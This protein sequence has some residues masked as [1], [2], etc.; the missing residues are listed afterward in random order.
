VI[1]SVALVWGG[2]QRAPTGRKAVD[3][4]LD[5]R[6]TRPPLYLDF[7]TLVESLGSQEGEARKVRYGRDEKAMGNWTI[8]D[9]G[10]L[11]RD[12]RLELRGSLPKILTGRNDALLDARGTHDG[13]RELV[14]LGDSLIRDARE[15]ANELRQRDGT[16]T[17]FDLRP[18]TLEDADPSR[19]D[20]VFHWDVPSVGFAIEHLKSYFK[21][22]RFDKL[23]TEHHAPKGGHSLV[24]GYGSK[25]VIR[26]YDKVAELAAH[27]EE[28]SAPLDTLLRFEIQDR[29][30]DRVR[31]IHHGGYTA[32]AVRR[33]LQ[34][35][36]SG[37]GALACRDVGAMLEG[38]S[39][40]AI[41][42]TF[43]YLHLVEHDEM[44]PIVR[45]L[46][47]PRTY[48]RYRRRVRELA[49]QV[50]DWAPVIPDDAFESGAS[51]WGGLDQ[52]ASTAS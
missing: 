29:L 35:T 30:R 20:Y 1:D 22:G 39:S 37:L 23:R 2:G 31:S 21:P 7:E 49:L 28:S 51:L 8:G 6:P 48:Q 41:L 3:P 25:R 13:L 40:R 32:T 47:T 9:V 18:L 4:F 52:V 15:R 26:F 12:G 17:S 11:Y 46:V 16:I 33:E 43:G 14:R 5:Q 38:A 34:R 10:V 27:G 42:P 36:V 24:Y 19:L 44:W 50:A 45:G